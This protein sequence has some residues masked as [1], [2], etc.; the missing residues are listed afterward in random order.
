MVVTLNVGRAESKRCQ[1]N[2]EDTLMRWAP[3]THPVGYDTILAGSAFKTPSAGL[4]IE[5]EWKKEGK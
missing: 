2:R 5:A 4:S 3:G 1:S